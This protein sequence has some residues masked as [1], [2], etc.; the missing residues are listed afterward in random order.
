M[1]QSSTGILI[2]LL[3]VA[4]II[5]DVAAYCLWGTDGTLSKSM[6]MIGLNWPIVIV[7][8]G[9]LSCHF[10]V[11]HYSAWPGWWAILKPVLCLG[12]GFVAFAVAWRQSI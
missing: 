2:S 10:F 1:N 11:P 3:F 4:G 5:Y 7:A 12:T 6:Q 8:Y 9:G